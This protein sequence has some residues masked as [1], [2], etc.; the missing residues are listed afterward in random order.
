MGSTCPD[1]IAAGILSLC[2]RGKPV[3]DGLIFE[4]TDLALASDEQTALSASR[5]IFTGIAEPLADRFEPALCDEYNAVFAKLMARAGG[6]DLRVRGL[7]T[8][9]RAGAPEVVVLSRVTL[10]ADVAITSVILDAAKRAFPEADIYFAGPQKNWELF[11]ADGRLRHLPVHYG[12]AAT[13]RERLAAGMELKSLLKDRDAIVI[14]PDSRLTQLGLLRVCPEDR[15]FHF[16]SRSYGGD[17]KD[18]LPLL[19][20]RWVEEVFG[21]SDAKAYIAPQAG[22]GAPA[23]ITISFGAGD[24][25]AKR[26]PDPFEERLLQALAAM[27]LPILVD[28]GAGGEEAARVERAAAN[29]AGVQTWEGAFAPFASAIAQSRLYVGYDS[30]GQ[31]VAAACGTPLVCIFRGYASDRA[32]WRWRPDGTGPATVI[33]AEGLNWEAALEKTIVAVRRSAQPTASVD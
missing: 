20:K 6:A 23:G 32:F 30:A 9:R 18:A 24:N 3:P 14:D 27:R 1:E 10:G 4:L 17:G 22:P 16:E 8:A 5:A 19:T 31:H 28:K 11:A 15:Y 21:V 25:P 33:A 13:L 12:R 29:L 26:V 2:L 7:H